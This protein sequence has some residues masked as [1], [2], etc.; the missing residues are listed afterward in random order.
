MDAENKTVNSMTDLELAARI[1]QQWSV[2][3]QTQANLQILNN[4][5]QRRQNAGTTI[6]TERDDDGSTQ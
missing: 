6:T 4:E 2:L 5:L 1:N 3:A